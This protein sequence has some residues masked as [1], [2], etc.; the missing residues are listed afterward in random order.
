V[1]RNNRELLDFIVNKK[2][3]K[4]NLS[5]TRICVRE[6]FIEALEWW[7]DAELIALF[8]DAAISGQWRMLDSLYKNGDINKH[9]ML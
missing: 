6:G 7:K 5:S 2:P 1:A 3:T 8:A 4:F 9:P